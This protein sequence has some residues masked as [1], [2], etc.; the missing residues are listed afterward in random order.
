MTQHGC[1]RP[2]KA[3]AAVD[4][5]TILLKDIH[6]KAA[7]VNVADLPRPPEGTSEPTWVSLIHEFPDFSLRIQICHTCAK[8][9]LREVQDIY[10]GCTQEEVTISHLIVSMIPLENYGREEELG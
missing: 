4:R 2:K 1:K 5:F 9:H 3:P 6:F 7:W 8:I 10:L